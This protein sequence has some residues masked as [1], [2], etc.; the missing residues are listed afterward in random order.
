MSES[1]SKVT[2]STA[3]TVAAMAPPKK[4]PKKKGR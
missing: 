3:A 1:K 2:R 4:V